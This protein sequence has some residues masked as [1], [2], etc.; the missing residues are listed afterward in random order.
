MIDSEIELV[1]HS[2]KVAADAGT[3]FGIRLFDLLA[4]SRPFRFLSLFV[5][6]PLCSSWSA[7]RALPLLLTL[8]ALSRS[9]ECASVLTFSTT[10]C[11]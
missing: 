7:R 4:I 8:A 3:L 2:L 11:Y 10:S 1:W 5:S 6:Q 9:A